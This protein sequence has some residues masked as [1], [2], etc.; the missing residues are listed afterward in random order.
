LGD[1]QAGDTGQTVTVNDAGKIFAETYGIRLY[2]YDTATH[3]LG[4]IDSRY[5]G[6]QQSGDSTTTQSSLVND[7]K[8]TGDSYGVYHDGSEAFSLVNKGRIEGG[9]NSFYASDNSDATVENTGM[10]VGDI[11]FHN[12]ADMYD[13]RGGTVLGSVHGGA[14]GDK[15]YG[16]AEANVL[17]GDAGLDTLDGGKGADK[18]YGGAGADHF[19][20][21]T[22]DGKDT[23]G[24]FTATGS[25]H[26]VVDLRH[27]SGLTDFADLKAHDMTSHNGDVIIDTG[28]G[29]T[30]TLDGVTIKDLV[31]ADFLF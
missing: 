20:F 1:S 13:G 8:I 17:Y 2:G 23:I 11:A 30:I 29:D 18:L 12:G 5:V 28:H 9:T 7:G 22:G 26:D 27:V 31:A 4:T 25:G 24:D 14:G 21:K 3:N 15:L 10:M 6:Y 19:L 16:G